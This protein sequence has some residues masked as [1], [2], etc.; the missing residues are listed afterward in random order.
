MQ[1]DV[2]AREIEWKNHF[3]VIKATEGKNLCLSETTDA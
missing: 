2:I 1:L 3:A